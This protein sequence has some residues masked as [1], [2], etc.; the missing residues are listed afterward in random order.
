MACR[1]RDRDLV[2]DG[3]AESHLSAF[4]H[5]SRGDNWIKSNR[6]E[7]TRGLTIRFHLPQDS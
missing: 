5:I 1:G 2:S 6:Y 7:L 3:V 4:T